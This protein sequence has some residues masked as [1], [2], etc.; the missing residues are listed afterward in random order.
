MDAGVPGL[1]MI[2]TS[3]SEVSEDGMDCTFRPP[4]NP[5]MSTSAANEAEAQSVR[6]M[7]LLSGILMGSLSLFIQSGQV[8]SG[9]VSES[10]RAV[11]NFVQ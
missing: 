10:S 9:Q 2:A 6:K 5:S 7:R 4:P 8:T 1:D 11:L 3:F